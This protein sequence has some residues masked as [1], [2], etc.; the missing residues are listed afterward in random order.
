MAIHIGRRG[1]IS[2]LSG[3]AVLPFVARAQ[4]PAIPV[5]GFL[6]L[7]LPDVF[8]DRLRGFQ[9][10]LKEAGYVEGENVTI[11]YRWAENQNDRLP[12]LAVEL[13]RRRVAVVVAAGPLL[14][15]P[16]RRKLPQFPRCSWSVT[17]RCGLA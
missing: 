11:D 12:G 10:G 16:R 9:R 13:A 3:A 17:T 6:W 2:T 1:F 15:S 7:S 5:V 8:A 4:Q 14:H